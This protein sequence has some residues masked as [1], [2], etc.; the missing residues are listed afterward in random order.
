MK[1]LLV[2]LLA[3]VM[4]FGLATNAFA[5][6]TDQTGQDSAAVDA[7][8]YLTALG[9]TN[10]YTD[11]TYGYDATI[12]RAEFAKIACGLAGL[13]D[14]ADA[15]ANTSSRY[16]D[17]AIG[18]W[19][20]GWVNLASAQG[21]LQGYPDG[22]FKPNATISMQEVATV[23][24]RIA[25]YDDNLAGSWPYDYIAQAGKV[26][27]TDDVTFVANAAATR[28]GVAVMAANLLDCEVMYWDTDKDRFLEVDG[29]ADV[30]YTVLSDSFDSYTEEDVYFP[31]NGSIVGAWIVTD[32][33]DMSLALNVYRDADDA[34]EDG[35]GT[36][37][38]E[39][40]AAGTPDEVDLADNYY[41]SGSMPLAYLYGLKA[42]L[43]YNED[44]E[45]I[46]IDLNSSMNATD[47]VVLS[48]DG[49]DGTDVTD[50]TIE[51]GDKAYKLA[52]DV[53][54]TNFFAGFGLS[55]NGDEADIDYAVY[56]LDEDG[57]L[58]AISNLT[59]YRGYPGEEPAIVDE[60]DSNS[61]K[62]TMLD[63]DDI[64]LTDEDFLIINK[65]GQIIEPTALV[66]GDVIYN[67]NLDA[68]GYTGD[69]DMV[70]QVGSMG[71][72]TLSKANGSG[73]ITI[74]GYGYAYNYL[75]ITNLDEVMAGTALPN[76]EA[77][78]AYYTTDGIDGDYTEFTTA[79]ADL[80]A[81]EDLFS[82]DVSFVTYQNPYVVAYVIGSAD[83]AS[84]YVYG[85]VTDYSEGSHTTDISSITVYNQDGETVE[86][87]LDDSYAATTYEDGVSTDE[88]IIAGA[89]VEFKL[90]SDGEVSNFDADGAI[91]NPD[92]AVVGFDDADNISG[93]KIKIDGTWYTL[94]DDAIIM[95]AVSE[96]GAG[97]ADWADYDEANVVSAD[98]VLAADEF[99]TVG[100]YIADTSGSNTITR[101]YI[102][103]SS[104][105]GGEDYGVISDV[106][107]DGGD[108]DMY[109]ILG[110]AA[111]EL[112]GVTT[113]VENDFVAYEA[114]SDIAINSILISFEDTQEVA[115]ADLL[116]LI[117]AEDINWVF[118]NGTL[119]TDVTGSADILCEDSAVD[120][121]VVTINDEY[122]YLTDST[123]V[124]CVDEDGDV[125]AGDINDV[126]DGSDIIALVDTDDESDLIIVF[127]VDADYV[128]AN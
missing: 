73:T 9:I 85:I 12:T 84:D 121:D 112:D 62:I 96:D 68:Y 88:E 25:G 65:Y 67:L 4:V 110:D 50:Y 26:D 102:V 81:L 61:E 45:V 120:D 24:L 95:E 119:D 79:S 117:D 49:D 28:A 86:Y 83:A 34:D 71:A 78:P 108:A 70:L 111:Y 103:D 118:A 56:Y 51:L 105:G 54:V 40:A 125:T 7:S 1:K 60:Y 16:S 66:Q 32:Y 94:A 14:S 5:Y 22:T 98:D 33:D 76:I 44:D 15:L 43:V 55:D 47:D 122:F 123:V 30:D 87:G 2:V 37:V 124:Y 104:L 59:F 3:L 19:Y 116:D 127:V 63:G 80:A 35:Y 99:A 52:E 100:Y 113:A 57:D 27:L 6:Y 128:F 48:V 97:I 17:V 82:T 106:Y 107:F 38:D 46:Y 11:G 8:Y 72:G 89:Y 75:S 58:Y 114:A 115:E 53:D 109:E 20:T 77:T 18:S 41:V 21:Y 36:A 42:D 92:D 74:G 13:S 29:D 90:N 10:G 91:I 23:L 69:V 39:F 93:S 126:D 101:L 31:T 64:D